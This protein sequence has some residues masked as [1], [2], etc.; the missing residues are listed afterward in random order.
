MGEEYGEVGEP[1]PQAT[2]LCSNALSS[3]RQLL[4]QQAEKLKT[5]LAASTQK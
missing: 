5:L 1:H 3:Y 4:D 2:M